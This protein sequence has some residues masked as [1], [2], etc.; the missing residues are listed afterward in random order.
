[1]GLVNYGGR[2]VWSRS[3]THQWCDDGGQPVEFHVPFS[4]RDGLVVTNPTAG[5]AVSAMPAASAMDP[6]EQGATPSTPSASAIDSKPTGFLSSW[7]A[8]KKKAWINVQSTHLRWVMEVHSLIWRIFRWIRNSGRVYFWAC[9][10]DGRW[11][12]GDS[13]EY[14]LARIDRPFLCIEQKELLL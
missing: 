6:Q 2:E 1:M 11:F 14:V 4:V 5:P 10:T 7:S 13:L 8:E 9:R 12:E 3:S